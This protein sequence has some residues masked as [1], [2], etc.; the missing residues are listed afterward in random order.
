MMKGI[1]GLVVAL[2]L[3]ALVLAFV[4]GVTLWTGL[5]ILALVIAAPIAGGLVALFVPGPMILRIVAG[6][7]VSIV[8][9]VYGLRYLEVL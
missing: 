2:A 6:L 8:A 1:L 3:V 7:S 9:L 5:L 4:F